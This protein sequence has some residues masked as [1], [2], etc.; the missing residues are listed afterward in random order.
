MTLNYRQEVQQ[1][2]RQLCPGSC[3]PSDEP[4][5]KRWKST[6]M[7][8]WWNRSSWGQGSAREGRVGCMSPYWLA[9]HSPWFLGSS[10]PYS[11]WNCSNTPLHV[12]Q[13]LHDFNDLWGHHFPEKKPTRKWTSS[14]GPDVLFITACLLNKWIMSGAWNSTF[15]EC[16]FV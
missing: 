15:Q 12:S 9:R 7:H 16:I 6:Y 3:P 14:P 11:K 4:V 5:V 1:R 8:I 10:V 2:L 13:C